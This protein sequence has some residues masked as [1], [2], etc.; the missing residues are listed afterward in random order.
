MS[1]DVTVVELTGRELSEVRPGTPLA[2]NRDHWCCLQVS[3]DLLPLP[4]SP[5]GEVEVSHGIPLLLTGS[6]VITTLTIL[7]PS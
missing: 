1:L 6:A 5:Q 2:V 4:V 3:D 7:Q